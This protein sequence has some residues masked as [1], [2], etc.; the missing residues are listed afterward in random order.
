MDLLEHF[1]ERDANVRLGS[2]TFKIYDCKYCGSTLWG[3]EQAKNHF[4]RNHENALAGIAP[5]YCAGDFLYMYFDEEVQI[6]GV[7]TGCRFDDEKKRY[8][9][10]VKWDDEVF[11][12]SMELEKEYPESYFAIVSPEVVEAINTAANNFIEEIEPLCS[13]SV[14]ICQDGVD[15]KVVFTAKTVERN[16]NS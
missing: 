2:E 12:E 1:N 6:R 3:K 15:M 7:L 10:S 16:K 14:G 9:L 5:E 4:E 8:L 13:G 11:A